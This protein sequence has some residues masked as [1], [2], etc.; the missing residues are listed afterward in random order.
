MKSNETSSQVPSYLSKVFKCDLNKART[1]KEN[2]VKRLSPSQFQ[3]TYNDLFG[4]FLTLSEL[5]AL[6][7]SL[8]FSLIPE[9][10][11]EEM[12]DFDHSVTQ[13]HIE[14]YLQ[15]AE[16]AADYI[17]ANTTL[18]SKVFGA[19]SSNINDEVCLNH[20]IDRFGLLS[21][22]RPLSQGQKDYYK[23]VFQL[24]SDE[25]Y[26]NLLVVFLSSPFFVYQ[27]EMATEQGVDNQSYYLTS[28]EIAARLSYLYLRS[29]PDDELFQ[30]AETSQLRTSQEISRQVDRLLKK[31]VAKKRL[32]EDFANQWL[33]LKETPELKTSVASVQDM[34][35]KMSVSE[36]PEK[37]R[38]HLIQEVYDYMYYHIWVAQSSFKEIMSSGIV[39]PKTDDLAEI[40]QTPKWN[41]SFEDSDLVHAP[42]GTRSG[43]LTLAQSL[44]TGTG[45]TRPILRGVHAYT[46]FLCGKL[47]APADNNTPEGVV[48]HPDFSEIE[49]VRAITEKPGTSCVGCHRNVINPIG[50]SFEHFDSFGRYRL[51]ESIYAD[52]AGA[53][54]GSIVATKPINL[55]FQVNLA[56]FEAP[57]YVTKANTLTEAYAANVEAGACFSRKLWKFVES[58]NH[59]EEEGDCAAQD[60]YLRGVEDAQGS[61]AEM[62]KQSALQPEFILKR[63]D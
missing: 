37:R 38:Q 40:Y 56:Q 46:R 33:H 31:E 59:K 23:Q 48:L 15:V 34:I 28:Y 44:F 54:Q 53:E 30:A 3:N 52:D 26:R 36:T 18:S 27:I 58:K 57:I 50:F 41:G 1:P 4:R 21:L 19:C 49:K 17:I 35:S 6:M 62:L 7:D 12:T 9:N 47:P 29:M 63:M 39:F 14:A 11:D 10:S 22:R 55:Y 2:L 51:N 20:F 61:V 25:G 32:A 60:L 5:S 43:V 8:N 45:R 24:R 13:S 16:Q 42:S